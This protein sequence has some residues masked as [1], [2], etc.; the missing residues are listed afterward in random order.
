MIEL[1][2]RIFGRAAAP[3]AATTSKDE[4]K[5][6]LKFLLIHDQVDLSP[7]QMD[8]MKAELMAVI[9]KYVEFDETDT[10]VRLERTD[11]QIALVSS[12][13]VRRVVERPNVPAPRASTPLP[14]AP[15]SAPLPVVPV[16]VVLAP[17]A[18]APVEPVAAAPV[19]APV[20]VTVAAPVV[21]TVEPDDEPVALDTPTLTGVTPEA[22]TQ[23]PDALAAS[24]A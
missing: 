22:P 13:P 12:V 19:A 5:Q 16:P 20:V 2:Q 8:A 18:P 9:S 24:A 7:A 23:Q 17:P 3:A 11:G 10:E 14:V 1:L 6:R 15:V 21:V 4:A